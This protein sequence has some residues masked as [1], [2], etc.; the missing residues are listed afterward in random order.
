MI[1]Y[2][3]KG[4]ERNSRHI[5]SFRKICTAAV[6]ICFRKFYYLLWVLGFS[7]CIY[8]RISRAEVL[9]AKDGSPKTNVIDDEVGGGL[10]CNQTKYNE[11]QTGLMLVAVYAQCVDSPEET[12]R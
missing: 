5:S 8:L 6:V 9:K 4:Y 3:A 11:L 10:L 7:T 1:L 2:C 12:L